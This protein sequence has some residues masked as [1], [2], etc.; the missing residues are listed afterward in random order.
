[1]DYQGFEFTQTCNACPEQYEVTLNGKQMAYLRL[2]HGYFYAAVPDCGGEVVYAAHPKGDGIFEWEERE[3]YLQ[4]A[5]DAIVLHYKLTEEIV[6]VFCCNC[7]HERW[8]NSINSDLITCANCS[9]YEPRFHQLKHTYNTPMNSLFLLEPTRNKYGIWS[10]NDETTGLVNEPFV[11]QTNDLID[12]MVIE[13]CLN[14]EDAAEGIA[15]VFSAEHFPGSQ[16]ELSLVNTSPTGT[17]Y[18][19]P[20][21]KLNPWLCPALFKYF[22]KAPE[23]LYAMVKA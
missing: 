12:A 23:R 10:F 17:T 1:M 14:I 3:E 15:L 16:V 18:R 11:G 4:K 7:K 2:R 9:P 13:K 20:K 22:P 19:C 21:F 8:T 6:R 5:L